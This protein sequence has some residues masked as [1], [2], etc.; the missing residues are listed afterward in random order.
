MAPPIDLKVELDLDGT[1]TDISSYVYNRDRIQIQRGRSGESAR[2]DPTRATITLNNRDGRF[3]PRNPMGVYYGLIG[4][5]T[6]IRMSVPY[7]ETYL[8]LP[9]DLATDSIKTADAAVLDITGDIDI[10]AYA[11]LAT[12]RVSQ[13]LAAKYNTTG[14]NRS[15]ALT[16][17]SGGTLTLYWS[18]DGTLANRRSATSTVPVGVS[19]GPLAVRATLDVNNGASGCTA[20]FY[21]APSISGPW[22]QLG[23][24]VTASGTTSIFSGNGDVEVG[25]AYFITSGVLGRFHAFQLYNGIAGTLVANPDFSIQTAG[26]TSFADTTSSPRTWTLWGSATLDDRDYRLHGEVSSWPQRYDTTGRDAW[27]PIQVAG[28]LQRLEQGDSPLQST[29][30][31]ALTASDQLNPPVAY[32]PCEDGSNATSLASGLEGGSAMKVYNEH[33]DYASFSDF[34]CSKP[35]P[36]VVDSQWEGNVGP[37]TE[38]SQQQVR[39][40]MYLETAVNDQR[41]FTVYTTG[42]AAKY[43]LFYSTGGSLDLRAYDADFT[44]LASTGAVAFNVDGKL[45]RVS[46]DISQVGSDVQF[47]VTALEVGQSSGAFT[48]ATA[49]GKTAGRVYRVGTNAGGGLVTAGTTCSFGHISVHNAVTSVFDLATELN[50][51]DGERAAVRMARLCD[52]EGIDFELVGASAD[53][54]AMGPQSPKALTDLLRECADADLGVLYEPRDRLGLGYRTRAELYNRE[55]G[56]TLTHSDHELSAPLDPVD[57]DQSTRND[58]TVT[59][60]N[61]SSYRAVLESGALSVLSPPHGVGRYDEGVSPNVESDEDLADQAGWRLHVGTVDEARYPQIAVNLR[62][63]SFTSDMARSARA[64]DGGDRLVVD[65][66][67]VNISTS[68]I[69]QLVVGSTE[70]VSGFEHTIAFNCI[71]ESPYQ[72]GVLDD[73]VLGRADTEG[74]TLYADVTSSATTM[75]V[76]TTSGPIWTTV[77]AEFPFDIEMGG[78]VL[79]VTEVRGA[80]GTFETS[81]A[82]DWS[83]TGCTLSTTGF[84]ART[85]TRSALMTVTGTPTQ[86]YI[87]PTATQRA[88]VVVGGSYTVSLW[89]M[90]TTGVSNVNISIDWFNSGGSY[91]STSTGTARTLAANT[92]T[93]LSLTATAPATAASA[94]YGPVLTGSPATGTELYVDDVDFP[95]P[96]YQVFEVTRS[97]NGVVKSH[98]AGADVR[99]AQS[100]IVSL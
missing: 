85:G 87:R 95:S 13:G 72:V 58:I 61:G 71:P 5:N 37:Y 54:A 53:S 17:D 39:F 63:P 55:A 80:E 77:T 88:Q 16:T 26:A 35:L 10:R 67:P 8:R 3:S 91:V 66:V 32:W 38:T 41:I 82:P 47:Q 78:E 98:T 59:R 4:R 65:G 76:A 94:G 12:W 30:Y 23:D 99:L 45:L 36:V 28:V 1:W 42:S 20:T 86:A 25:S 48:S 97:V 81:G 56:I 9:R 79:T 52:E 70:V 64:M 62:H 69:S 90:S 43:A 34:A 6:P 93:R 46:I 49:S 73:D 60:P 31:R 74:S 19:S 22:T 51:Y 75:N 18:T 84:R 50:A 83:A 100:M 2:V 29:L 11:S 96:A 92:W 40:L 89:V 15:W 68:D 21:T 27:V 7:G 44:L 57:D 14:D 33:P 24:A